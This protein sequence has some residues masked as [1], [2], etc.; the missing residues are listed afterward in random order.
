MEEC[1][2]CG[3]PFNAEE[4]EEGY[5]PGCLRRVMLEE[6]EAVRREWA[7]DMAIFEPDRPRP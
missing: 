6:E 4:G 3:E 7:E 2:L 5:C 1:G